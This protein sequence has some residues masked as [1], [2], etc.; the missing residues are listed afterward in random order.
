[1]DSLADI[2][3]TAARW[4]AR[5][6]SESWSATDDTELAQ[7]LNASTGNVIAYMRMEAAWQQANRLKALGAGFERGTVP[8]MEDLQASPFFSRLGKRLHPSGRV[9]SFAR[10]HKV[11]AVAASVLMAIASGYWGWTVL[12]PRNTYST[13]IGVTAAVPLPDGSRITLNTNSKIRVAVTERE[14][15]VELNHGEAFFEVAKDRQHPFVVKAGDK[16]IVVVGTKFSVRREGSDVRV[17]VTEGVV[18]VEQERAGAQA[19]SAQLI[20]GNVALSKN[21]SMA[22]QQRTPPEAEELLSW[23]SGYLVFHE[24]SLADAVAE[25]NRYNTVA[26]IVEDPAVATL[27]VSGNFRATNVDSF[28]RLLE[29]GFPVVVDRQGDRIV[30]TRRPTP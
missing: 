3:D 1:M 28:S 25:F 29:D 26:F 15:R 11:F 4:I 21:G 18:R 13:P 17:V 23:R 12:H 19:P 24:T 5:R 6:S 20:A 8:S 2:K 22:I 27:A 9:A 14:R 7:W 16:R 30:L 10:T